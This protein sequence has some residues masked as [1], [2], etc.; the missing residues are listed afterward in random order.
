M[1]DKAENLPERQ[2]K[3]GGSADSSQQQP[4][5][6]GGHARQGGGHAGQQSGG[7]GGMHGGDLHDVGSAQSG[8]TGGAGMGGND[9]VRQAPEEG[10]ADSRQIADEGNLQGATTDQ[11]AQRE[12]MGRHRHVRA[13]EQDIDAARD[14]DAVGGRQPGAQDAR[15]S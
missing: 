4:V 6:Q 11:S 13:N 10:Q 8:M 5:D 15:R 9:T 2:G 14:I 12:G 3:Q 7:M 1:T